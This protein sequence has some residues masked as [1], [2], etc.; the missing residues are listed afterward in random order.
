MIWQQWYRERSAPCWQADGLHKLA[1]PWRTVRRSASSASP[2][3][4]RGGWD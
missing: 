2:G 1:P 3:Q 4:C